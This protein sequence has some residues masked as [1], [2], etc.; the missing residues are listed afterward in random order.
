MAA[1][2]ATGW[3][4]RGVLKIASSVKYSAILAGETTD[5]SE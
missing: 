1:G 4:C 5:Q 2:P 3:T